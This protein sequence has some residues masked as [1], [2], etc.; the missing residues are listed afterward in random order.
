ME[1]AKNAQRKFKNHETDQRQ[2]NASLY[3]S[4]SFSCSMPQFLFCATG[5]ISKQIK[6]REGHH[7]VNCFPKVRV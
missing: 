2:K 6:N 4:F 3:F 1:K 7:Q 5:S